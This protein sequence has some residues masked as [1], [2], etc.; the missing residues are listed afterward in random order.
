MM[1]TWLSCGDER[2]SRIC[3]YGS[4]CCSACRSSSG[5][6]RV[7]QGGARC[8]CSG[9]RGHGR[10]AGRVAEPGPH[11]RGAE[12]VHQRHSDGEARYILEIL[13]EE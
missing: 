2:N 12:A 10:H 11:L 5:P 9:E 3:I 6:P 8:V 4:G 7:L 13:Q 1:P